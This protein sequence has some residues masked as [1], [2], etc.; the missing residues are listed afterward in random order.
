MQSLVSS[1]LD[2]VCPAISVAVRQ[3]HAEQSNIPSASTLSRHRLTL[4]CGYLVV[5]RHFNRRLLDDG[6]QP[7]R[8]GTCDASPQGGRAWLLCGSTVIAG[9][10]V[11][12]AFEQAVSLIEAQQRINEELEVGLGTG[13]DDGADGDAIRQD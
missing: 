10:C 2:A 9:S 4:H 6:A 13:G 5:L 3:A 12:Q 8:Y 11:T 7:A 1:C